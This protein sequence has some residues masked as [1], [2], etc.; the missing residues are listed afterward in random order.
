MHHYLPHLLED[1]AAGH[2]PD[3]KAVCEEKRNP[4]LADVTLEFE[5]MRQ[6]P[7]HTLGYYSGLGSEGFPPAEH[8]NNKEV[9]E[10]CRAFK[11]M[12][13]SWNLR[14]SPPKGLPV[15]MQYVLL[16]GTLERRIDPETSFS[17]VFAYCR[18]NPG[19][20]PLAQYCTC[21]KRE[22]SGAGNPGSD[23]YSGGFIEI[24]V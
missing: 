7:G 18:R 11:K 13:R 20:C 17:V 1:I 10:V 16:I 21:L 12:M 3:R 19:D 22:K 24:K 23:D 14:C 5:Q 4:D 15:R 2:Q 9:L 6:E 8:L